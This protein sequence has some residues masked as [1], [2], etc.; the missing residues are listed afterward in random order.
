[1]RCAE[2]SSGTGSRNALLSRQGAC[3]GGVLRLQQTFAPRFRRGPW[4]TDS[5]IA[6]EPRTRFQLG[7]ALNLRLAFPQDLPHR[8]FG[9]ISPIL[10]ICAPTPRNFSSM[11]S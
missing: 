4:T 5:L 7:E 2:F 9:R 11:F 1:M 3:I 8:F 6:C 10:R